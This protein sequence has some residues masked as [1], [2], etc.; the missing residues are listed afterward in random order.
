M[1]TMF[2]RVAQA[3]GY[4]LAIA[5]HDLAD[6]PVEAATKAALEAMQ[7][8]LIALAQQRKA[9]YEAK[10]AT[11]D[12]FAVGDLNPHDMSAF[13]VEV[14]DYVESDLRAAIIAR[15]SRQP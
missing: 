15:P 1:E 9:I 14:M 2:E 6:G 3:V 11:R 10:V 5:G 13:A 8:P 7:E 12:P 4:A